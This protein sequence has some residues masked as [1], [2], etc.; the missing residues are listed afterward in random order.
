MSFEREVPMTIR[1]LVLNWRDAR[2]TQECVE[3]LL[4]VPTIDLVVVVDNEA[5]GTLRALLA[6]RDRVSLIELEEN[7]GF[8]GGVNAGLALAAEA[9]SVLVINNDATIDA[10]SVDALERALAADRSAGVVSPRILNPDGSVQSM[11]GRVSRLSGVA[12]QNT[13]LGE[14]IDYLSWACVLVRSEVFSRV[15]ILDER[16]FM[17]WEDTE[18]S[19]RV[20]AAGYGLSIVED[21]HV[22]H[23]LSASGSS[24][25]RLLAT[26]YAWSLLAYG[27]KLG[28]LAKIRSR[29]GFAAL[30]LKRLAA[31]DL[32]GARAIARA[33]GLQGAEPAWRRRSDALSRPADR[34]V[35]VNAKWLSQST[36][37]TQ[38]YATEVTKRLVADHGRRIVLVVPADATVPEWA[39]GARIR[40]SRLRGMAFEQIALPLATGGRYLLTMSGAAPL[41]KWRQG[42]V[43]HDASV[44][45]FGD[46]FSRA[47]T[48]WYRLSYRTAPRRARHIFTV[49]EFSRGELSQFLHVPSERIIVAPCGADHWLDVRPG[50]RQVPAEPYVVAVGSLTKRKNLSP[51]LQ[52]LARRGVPTVV[53]GAGDRL[54]FG[55]SAMPADD[56]VVTVGRISDGDLRRLL[57]GAIAMIFPSRYEGFGLP[58]VE[59][60]SEGCPVVCSTASSLPEVAGDGA[61]FFDVDDPDAAVAH[62]ESLRD[63]AVIR[64][65]VVER[66]RRNADR[67]TWSAT[68]RIIAHH[69]LER[70]Q[71]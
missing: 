21:A 69:V 31:R 23:E 50:D 43:I 71:P 52:A 3:A 28:G 8:S 7:R 59:A 10:A 32:T 22:H 34:R 64:A 39:R 56:R 60:Q 38:R 44:F 1:A 70:Q 45:R 14:R 48:T 54:V 53:V 67:F 46:T 66:G 5:D 12:R 57:G 15:G 4:A 9:D 25:G 17:Y 68:S 13:T 11:G 6:E 63:N 26:Y 42:I 40:R 35:Y 37:G 65:D 33:R 55:G 58:I 27:D 29:V 62:V 36:T 49:S 20:R 47:F 18:F 16:F 51:T 2:R 19:H 30:F 24:A 61:L 41:L